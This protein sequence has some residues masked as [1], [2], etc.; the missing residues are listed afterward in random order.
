M[1]TKAGVVRASCF[2]LALTVDA[3]MGIDDDPTPATRGIMVSH[4]PAHRATTVTELSYPEI[5]TAQW[6]FHRKTPPFPNLN[7]A[8]KL[9]KPLLC[10][11]LESEFATTPIEIPGFIDRFATPA[12]SQS[13]PGRSGFASRTQT[14]CIVS[15]LGAAICFGRTARFLEI[16]A[17]PCLNIFDEESCL[18]IT[19]TQRF[20]LCSTT[21]VGLWLL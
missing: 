18:V 16:C 20:F 21:I 11:D 2:L 12:C 6:R 1:R 5:T 13:E 3:I 7:G 19:V 15:T 9:S 4:S 8:L 14:G 17:G 10:L